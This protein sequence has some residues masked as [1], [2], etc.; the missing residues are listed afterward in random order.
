MTTVSRMASTRRTRWFHLRGPTRLRARS[1]EVLIVRLAAVHGVLRQLE[2][3]H[4]LPV[5]EQSTSDAG[6]QRHGQLDSLPRDDAEALHLRVVEHADRPCQRARKG[7]RQVEA[8][9]L[10]T[11]EVGCPFFRSGSPL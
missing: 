8:V 3:R 2:M 11:A 1:A 5:A 4:Q 7:A 10:R 6:S 9:P